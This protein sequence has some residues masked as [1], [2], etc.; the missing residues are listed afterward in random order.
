MMTSE[1]NVRISGSKIF[2]GRSIEDGGE[3]D[4]PGPD[5]SQPYVKY[6]Q[7][8]NLLVKIIDDI[9]TFCS[10]VSTH[11][12]PGYGAPSVQINNAVSTLLSA[13]NDR[14]AEIPSIKSNRIFG[15]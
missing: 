6:Q 2:I 13:M 1:G 3:G 10:T 8:E 12:T 4:G 9:R 15:E 5:G 14:E 11:T 7:L